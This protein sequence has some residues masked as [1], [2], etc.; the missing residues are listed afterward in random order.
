M[1]AVAQATA[2]P[3]RDAFRDLSHEIP[4]WIQLVDVAAISLEEGRNTGA[5][6]TQPDLL[7]GLNKLIE[8]CK[9]FSSEATR[10]FKGNDQSAQMT[11]E[12]P[13]GGERT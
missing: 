5:F 9:E 3:K 10:R 1:A 7:A 12:V 11:A 13:D 8:M 4:T 6:H 2:A